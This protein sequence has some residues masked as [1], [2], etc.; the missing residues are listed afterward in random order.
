LGQGVCVWQPPGHSHSHAATRVDGLTTEVREARG[1]EEE[2]SS[3]AEAHQVQRVCQSQCQPKP[4][5][6]PMADP[7]ASS[8]VLLSFQSQLRSS[9]HQDST[10]A[11]SRGRWAWE[12]RRS[13]FIGVAWSVWVSC[14]ES[15]R[16]AGSSGGDGRQSR[17]RLNNNSSH[18]DLTTTATLLPNY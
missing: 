2:R 18:L 1:Q 15:Q 14:S 16:L 6:D 17:A 11:C 9:A 13:G 10:R 4:E 3:A 8:L 7:R 12:G 5:L